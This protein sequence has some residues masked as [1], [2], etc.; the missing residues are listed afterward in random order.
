MRSSIETR[1]GARRYRIARRLAPHVAPG[2]AE[3]FV[4]ELRLLG[5]EGTRIGDA[6]SEVESHCAESTECAQQ[7]FG[8]PADYARSL[9]LPTPA[10]TSP[11]ALLRSVLPTVAEV[12]GM[13][14][15][16]WGFAAWREGSPLE[17]TTGDLVTG[18]IVLLGVAA[19]VRF[20]DSVLR[21]LVH[22]PVLLWLV[23]MA[24]MAAIALAS[25]FLGAVI[26]RM[27]AGWS[28]A[29]GATALVG[30]VVWVFARRRAAPSTDGPVTPP[31][32]A[33]PHPTVDA[34]RPDWGSFVCSL[35]LGPAWIL[36]CTL[37]LL[38]ATSWLT[39]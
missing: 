21:S 36:L 5:V 39:R 33:G 27:A 13:L 18:V 16:V 14:A 15:L 35:V 6:L 25:N 32:G 4:V 26:W 20:A 3:E 37:V 8:D 34:P 2:W 10:Y 12:L 31:L 7:A 19:L 38:A 22:H 11:R 9:D 1:A 28:V 30:G 23:V 29:T 24:N 17:I